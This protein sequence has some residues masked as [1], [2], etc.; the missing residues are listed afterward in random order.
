MEGA[1]FNC[2]CWTPVIFTYGL[3]LNLDVL[4]GYILFFFFLDL[5]KPTFSYIDMVQK[6]CQ[7]VG[8]IKSKKSSKKIVSESF[9]FFGHAYEI[10]LPY[11]NAY[12]IGYTLEK[13]FRWVYMCCWTGYGF[14]SLKRGFQLHYFASSRRWY[15]ME[16]C[17]SKL[18]IERSFEINRMP[19]AG[20]EFLINRALIK[21]IYLAITHVK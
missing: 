19:S 3:L 4:E 7:L 1:G 12:I 14:I 9:N 2:C 16:W 15:S 17:C 21:K 13:S 20:S 10:Q 6:L 18:G 5:G 8:G 11:I